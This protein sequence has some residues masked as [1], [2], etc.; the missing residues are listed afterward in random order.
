MVQV[1][2]KLDKSIEPNCRSVRSS[3]LKFSKIVVVT[4]FKSGRDM[5]SIFLFKLP[6]LSVSTAGGVVYTLS[7]SWLCIFLHAFHFSNDYWVLLQF[8]F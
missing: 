7:L 8:T 5:P 1:E 3:F 2:L 4:L 6:G